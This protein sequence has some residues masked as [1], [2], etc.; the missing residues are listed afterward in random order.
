[1]RKSLLIDA[2]N[3]EV[4]AASTVMSLLPH[5][6]ST[7]FCEIGPVRYGLLLLCALGQ[8]ITI[9]IT[10]PLWQQ[11]ENP[12]HLPLVDLPQ[13]PFGWIL[14]ISLIVVAV[15]P[16][17]GV[18]LHALALL[19]SFA[20]DQFRTQP[21]FI[22]TAVL[23]IAVA[24]K[25]ASFLG[26]WFLVS[27]WFWS[28]LHKFLSPDWLGPGSW[29]FV[30]ALGLNQQRYHEVFAILI[31]LVEISQGV[32]AVIRPRFAAISCVLLHCGIVMF[33]SPWMYDWNVSVIPWNLCTAVVGCWLLWNANPVLPRTALEVTV[34]AIL[35]VFPVGF[36]FGWVDH[37]IASVLYSDNL[38]RGL[39]SSHEG[40]S[41]ITGWGTLRVP[42]PNERRLLLLY[43]ERVA[44]PGAKLHLS[45]PRSWLPDAYY[46][47][48]ADGSVT[49]ISE[50]RF[51]ETTEKEAAGIALDSRRSISALSQAGARMLK[52]TTGS[53]I[54]A[55]QIP[56]AKYDPKLLKHLEELPNLEQLQLAGCAV[57]DNDLAQL[58]G[59]RRLIGIGLD[60]TNVTDLG[61][62]HLKT[63]PRLTYIEH[64]N[65]KITDA[66]LGRIGQMT[67]PAAHSGGVLEKN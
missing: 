27:M 20:F 48:R 52:R 67:A 4:R 26:R 64:A 47:K 44:A 35:L 10:W 30:A 57:S 58:K 61:I 43:F 25:R 66:G 46:V 12:P 49:E 59:L 32:L 23:M 29:N 65:T 9:A 15:R 36:Y 39:I 17:L 41:Q 62:A 56:P 37:G 22:A 2:R 40:I 1:M 34:A 63:L 18:G 5:L 45:D 6:C 31:A 50:K 13:I 53:M 14:A 3:G 21:Q 16:R 8:A 19:T 7:P 51:F 24:D 28:G 33:L 54:Y 11:R 60:D 42:F 55:V 38:P